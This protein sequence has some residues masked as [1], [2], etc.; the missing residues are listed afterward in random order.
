LEGFERGPRVDGYDF[1]LGVAEWCA[2]IKMH[3]NV[4]ICV[5]YVLTYEVVLQSLSWSTQIC[6]GGKIYPVRSPGSSSYMYRAA[7]LT[8]HM[9]GESTACIDELHLVQHQTRG[10]WVCR[11]QDAHNCL[12]TCIYVPYVLTYEVL[13]QSIAWSVQI[14]SGGMISLVRSRRSSSFMCIL[15]Q[16]TRGHRD[17]WRAA[18]SI[19]DGEYVYAGIKICT[20]LYIY[21]Y[22]CVTPYM[23]L[24]MN[25]CY[26]ASHLAFKFA[27]AGR[28]LSSGRLG[29][30]LLCI[31]QQ[32]TRGRSVCRLHTCR[33]MACVHRSAACSIRHGEYVYAEIK[34]RATVYLCAIYM[35]FQYI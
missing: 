14:C 19:G 11:D 23:N 16:I 9:H 35:D 33:S 4:C 7:N 17:Q 21:L 29:R 24:H 8:S 6:S 3:T 13:L 26:K 5:P 28:S 10:I 30:R 22:I 15:Q 32:I 18:C 12:Y 25:R 34:M 1:I 2:V 31:L 20:R 27:A